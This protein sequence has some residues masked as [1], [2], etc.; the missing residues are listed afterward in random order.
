MA[1]CIYKNCIRLRRKNS[2]VCS[3]CT[4]RHHYWEKKDPAYRLERRRKLALSNETMVEF[5]SDTK[6]VTYV[7]KEHKVHVREVK[8]NE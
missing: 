6:L 8:K 7:R 5:I 3:A 4:S 2:L 1:K